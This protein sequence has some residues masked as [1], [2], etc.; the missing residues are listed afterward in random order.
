MND[1]K[2]AENGDIYL[3]HNGKMRRICYARPEEG[4]TGKQ[5]GFGY[6]WF[7][8]VV[9]SDGTAAKW[10]GLDMNVILHQRT[11]M[12]SKNVLENWRG[13]FDEGVSPSSGA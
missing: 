1:Y 9:F 7:W 13:K 12:C 11:M 5:K 6:A 10:S 8:D 3:R 2:L 4:D